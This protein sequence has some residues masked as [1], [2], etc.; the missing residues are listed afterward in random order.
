MVTVFE[1]I[2]A[3]FGFAADLMN[4]KVFGDISLMQLF[5]PMV[6]VVLVLGVVSLIAGISFVIGEGVSRSTRRLDAKA[7][8]AES[9]RRYAE[10]QRYRAE[11]RARA[12]A[13]E[14]RGKK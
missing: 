10:T 9:D 11:M 6:V 7:R 1:K 12:A 3:F 13:R 8:K 4:Y 2:G 14:K 5:A